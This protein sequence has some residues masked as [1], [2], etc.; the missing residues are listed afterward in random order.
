MVQRFDKIRRLLVHRQN[1][2][3]GVGNNV[4]YDTRK[5]LIYDTAER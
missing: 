2:L 1:I 3:T 5:Y 4:I